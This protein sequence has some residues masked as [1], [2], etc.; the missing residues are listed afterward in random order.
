MLPN[1]NHAHASNPCLLLVTIINISCHSGTL[2]AIVKFCVGS[3][4]DCGRC[5]G[6]RRWML[7]QNKKSGR[8]RPFSLPSRLSRTERSLFSLLSSLF[9]LLSLLSDVRMR[10]FLIPITHMHQI[11][12]YCLLENNQYILYQSWSFIKSLPTVR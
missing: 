5:R 11:L 8:G 9:P 3:S 6:H 1:T 7:K 12:A 4:A 2:C 10:C